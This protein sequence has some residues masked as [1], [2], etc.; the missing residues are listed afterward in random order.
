MS[1]ELGLEMLKYQLNGD[2]FSR[3]IEHLEA[4]FVK[5][6]YSANQCGHPIGLVFDSVC[7]GFSDGLPVI[8]TA[9]IPYTSSW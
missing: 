1:G 8:Q 2:S 9:N 7:R 3:A 6:I 5:S 4:R